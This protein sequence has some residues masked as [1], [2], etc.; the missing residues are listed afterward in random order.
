MILTPVHP[1]CSEW[2]L[3]HMVSGRKMVAY[4]N[5]CL[6]TPLT[7]SHSAKAQSRFIILTEFSEIRINI[8][9][10]E[11]ATNQIPASVPIYFLRSQSDRGLVWQT[12]GPAGSCRSGGPH[13]RWSCRAC[14]CCVQCP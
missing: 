2:G 7:S 11:M 8:G 4:E 5:H 14:S 3:S 13:P 9:K 1:E 12:A 6:I 10:R